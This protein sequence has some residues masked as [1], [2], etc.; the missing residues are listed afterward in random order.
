MTVLRR[1][2]QE[3]ESQGMGVTG[4]GE[5]REGL[6]DAGLLALQMKEGAGARSHGKQV[7]SGS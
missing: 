4:E 5:V 3:G 1:G 6:E 7:T 2:K